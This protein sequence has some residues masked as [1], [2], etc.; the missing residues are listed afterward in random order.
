MALVLILIMVVSALGLM[1]VKPANAQRFEQ[2][3]SFPTPSIPQFTV[4]IVNNSY[5]TQPITTIT[6]DPFTGQSTTTTTP[7][8]FVE[9]EFIELAIKNQSVT[10]QR[11]GIDLYF[12]VRTKGHFSKDWNYISTLDG[13]I[14][15]NYSSRYTIVT[16]YFDHDFPAVGQIDFQVRAIIGDIYVED[17]NT[18][19]QYEIVMGQNGGWTDI[20]T[21]SIPDGSV[22]ITPFTNPSPAPTQTPTSIQTPTPTPITTPTVPEFPTIVILLLLLSV[23]SITVVLRLKKRRI[24]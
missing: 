19:S 17:P 16:A 12:D 14:I 13:N 21:I 11:G 24:S 22:S 1:M 5:Y 4:R 7:S 10:F 8:R 6:T 2:D 18:L 20:Q 9:D 3:T 23:F 15:E